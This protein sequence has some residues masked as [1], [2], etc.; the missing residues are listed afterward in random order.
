MSSKLEKT[1]QALNIF[2][3]DEKFSLLVIQSWMMIQ[4]TEIKLKIK[5]GKGH[6]KC[7]WRSLGNEL[8]QMSTITN[9]LLWNVFCWIRS[10]DNFRVTW[11]FWNV[12][13]TVRIFLTILRLFLVWV[14]QIE[15]HQICTQAETQPGV[16]LHKTLIR[17]LDS[18]G[19]LRLFVCPPMNYF[20]TLRFVNF[21]RVFN[22][23]KCRAD[24]LQIK[25]RCHIQKLNFRINYTLKLCQIFFFV[26]VEVLTQ[27]LQFDPSLTRARM[28]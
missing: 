4:D 1:F 27:R 26:V 14:C 13:S 6:R 24:F 9:I 25:T 2:N 3:K 10:L 19:N 20:M 12:F 15:F 21:R 18:L 22:I 5:P 11:C 16:S 17:C 7:S 28:T 8:V 23:G